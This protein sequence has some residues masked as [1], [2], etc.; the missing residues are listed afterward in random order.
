MNS[1]GG[2]LIVARGGFRLNEEALEPPEGVPAEHEEETDQVAQRRVALLLGTLI[3][4]SGI[5]LFVSTFLP[6]FGGFTGWRIMFGPHLTPHSNMLY[7]SRAGLLV[8][9]GFWAMVFGVLIIA[10]GVMLLAGL[11]AGGVLAIVTALIAMTFSAISIVTIN[12]QNVSAGAG[13]FIFGA[14][15]LVSLM[16]GVASVPER[17]GNRN[18]NETM[19]TTPLRNAGGGAGRS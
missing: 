11:R 4:A 13:L 9:T 10:G 12:N 19:R 2:L 7:V 14:F 15:S 17:G 5:L 6:W 8:F 3:A 1:A 16:L 18:E